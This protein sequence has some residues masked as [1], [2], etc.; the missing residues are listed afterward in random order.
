[1]KLYDG[2]WAPS[3]RRVRI[4]LAEK[5][6]DVETVVIDLKR[7]E[8]L[9]P[10]FVQINAQRQLPALVLDDGTVLDDSLAIC[11]Y[12]EA[13]YPDP[14]LFGTDAREIGLVEAWLRRIEHDCFQAVAL[15]FRNRVPAFAGRAVSGQWPR[16]EQIPELADRGRSMWNAFA[17]ILDEHLAAQ[18]Y[19][20]GEA[21]TMADIA[22]LVAIEFG[23][24]TRLPDPREGH[25][26]IARWHTAVSARPSARA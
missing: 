21:F 12:F 15:A 11:R 23:I 5:R 3:P 9:M 1:M 10:D 14:P 22:A 19:I 20:A 24:D 26:A 18:S 7:G 16:I 17:D 8:H 6:I 13:L 4:Y 2:A 25:P